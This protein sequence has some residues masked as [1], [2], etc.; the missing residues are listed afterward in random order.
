MIRALLFDLDGTL[1][2]SDPLHFEVFADLFAERG[3]ELTEAGY[4]SDIHGRHNLESFPELFPGEDAQA[5][6][7][8]K[9]ARFRDKLGDGHAPMP[10]AEALM[11]RAKAQGWRIA[12][13]T[14]APRDNAEA[15]LG[16]TGLRA[17]AE[18]LVIGDECARAK[19]DPEPYAVAMRAFGVPP[20]E[21]I[22]FEDSPSGMRA[23]A[24]SGAHTV[25]ILSSGLSADQLRAAGAQTVIRDYTD[26]ALE[27]L[28]ARLE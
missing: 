19:P 21:C 22:A 27:E 14:N 26:P 6:S 3:R 16:A 25:G 20:Q 15:M 1:L 10:G 17:F 9:E 12:V 18:T 11:L 8:H 28:L 2:H 5:L 7:N 4:L 24:A 13:V 23:A